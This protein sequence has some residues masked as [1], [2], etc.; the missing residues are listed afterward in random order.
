M[1]VFR[2]CVVLRCKDV[3]LLHNVPL[4][5]ECQDWKSKQKKTR[6]DIRQDARFEKRPIYAL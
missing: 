2:L 4:V 6:K 5:I 3:E 1:S